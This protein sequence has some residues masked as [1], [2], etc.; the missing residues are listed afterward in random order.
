MSLEYLEPVSTEVLESIEG[1]PEHVL[2]KNMLIFTK[3]S[4]LPNM[5]NIK[6][7]LIF[8]NETNLLTSIYL[9]YLFVT[10]IFIFFLTSFYFTMGLN[11]DEWSKF[12]KVVFI[13]K[14]TPIP[15]L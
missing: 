12:L 15:K 2:G 13:F 14:Q 7:C 10:I 6:I 9:N 1:L 5:S 4:G 8:V 11:F 3:K